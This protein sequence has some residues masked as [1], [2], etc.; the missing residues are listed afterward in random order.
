LDRFYTATKWLNHWLLCRSPHSVHSPA[1]FQFYNEVIRK[2]YP[3]SEI[4]KIELQR[5]KFQSDHDEISWTELGAGSQTD[6][7]KRKISDLASQS[8]SPPVWCRLLHRLTEYLQ[9]KNI[10]ELGTCLGISTL[11]LS[12][13]DDSEV[14]TLE[15]NE[16]LKNP[17]GN[18]FKNLE[19]KN[20]RLITGNIDAT[21]PITLGSMPLLDMAFLDAN[22]RLNPTVAYA[23][24]IWN[25]LRPGGIL[26]TDDIHRSAEMGLAWKTICQLKGCAATIDLFRWG[27]AVK[28]PSVLNGHH[29]WTI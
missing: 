7:A 18:A 23:E 3:T 5:K 10:I 2:D 22:H 11:Y 16:S 15:G 19:R 21:L 28:G 4:N 25:H 26:I 8:L 1:L 6:V 12:I 29:R 27:I 20:I 9:A 14:T 13:R 24:K 17:A